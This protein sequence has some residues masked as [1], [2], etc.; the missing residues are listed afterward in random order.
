MSSRPPRNSRASRRSRSPTR[1][2][3]SRRRSRRRWRAKALALARHLQRFIFDPGYFQLLTL[4]AG[5]DERV[6]DL[7][8]ALR[9]RPANLAVLIHLAGEAGLAVLH[10]RGAM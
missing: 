1:W 9:R 4:V 8:L 2:T 5:G 3:G 6:A 7:R 10:H